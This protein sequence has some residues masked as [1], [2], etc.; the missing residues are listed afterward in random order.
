MKSKS[1]GKK[2]RQ[3]IVARKA[4]IET[5]LKH[6][7]TID[8]DFVFSSDDCH[9]KLSYQIGDIVRAS[10]YMPSES[11]DDWKYAL[12]ECRQELEKEEPETKTIRLVHVWDYPDDSLY[13]AG[14]EEGNNYLVLRTDTENDKPV[15]AVI[16]ASD[17]DIWGLRCNIT[18]IHDVMRE[19][20][21]WHL[22]KVGKDKDKIHLEPQSISLAETGYIPVRGTGNQDIARFS[23]PRR[24]PGL[25]S[26]MIPP[27]TE[28]CERL[29]DQAYL[30]EQK[31]R[32]KAQACKNIAKR[33]DF[34]DS[35]IMALSQAREE[36][37]REG[38][39]LEIKRRQR[40]MEHRAFRDV[41]QSRRSRTRNAHGTTTTSPV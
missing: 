1:T 40:I 33:L 22:G 38:W 26:P 6:G 36:W 16:E 10:T 32:I 20:T 13:E 37:E 19:A 4:I 29:L 41:E 15:Y 30:M 39:I 7:E 34:K 9:L 28:T 3:Q 14:D 31:C 23:P 21:S 25:Y 18:D 12:A 2:T 11:Q 8:L 35:E 17:E 5:A 24:P 27:S